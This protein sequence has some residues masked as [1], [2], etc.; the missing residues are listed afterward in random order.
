MPLDRTTPI[1]TPSGRHRSDSGARANHPNRNHSLKRLGSSLL[2]FVLTLLVSFVTSVSAQQSPSQVKEIEDR[3]VKLNLDATK[4]MLKGE[5]DTPLAMMNEALALSEKHFGNDDPFTSMCLVGLGKIYINNGQYEQAKVTLFRALKTLERSPF[6]TRTEVADAKQLL[7]F[8]YEYQSDYI[9]A[10]Q[11]YEQSLALYEAA[12]G[13][14][15]EQVAQ[16]LNNLANLYIQKAD[17]V[18]AAQMLER[19]LAIRQRVFGPTHPLIAIVLNNLA[20]VYEWQGNVARAEELFEQAI[21]IGEKSSS[22]GVGL[23]QLLTNLGALYR[24]NDP[25]KARILLERGLEMREKH[26]GPEAEEVGNSLNNLALLDWQEGK[27]KLSEQKLLR[28]LSILQKTLGP[29]HPDT[30][31]IVTNLA[32]LYSAVGERERALNLLMSGSDNSDRHLE[33][34]LTTGSEEQKRLYM[35]TLSDATSAFVSLHL[36]YNFSNPLAARLALTRILRRKGRILDMMSGQFAAVEKS[37]VAGQS[38]ITKLTNVRGQLSS[39]SIQGPLNSEVN[40]Y[41]SQLSRL[42]D[43]VQSLEKSITERVANVASKSSLLTI[44]DVQKTIPPGFALVEIIQY[45]PMVIGPKTLPRWEDPHYA[46]YVLTKTGQPS[47]IDLGIAAKIDQS[48]KGLRAAL[49]NPRRTDFPMLARDV[50]ERVM[51]PIR[52]LLGN[53]KQVLLAPDGML[54][55]APFAAFQNEHNHFLVEDYS[56]TYLTSGR[57]LLRMNNSLPNRQGPVIIA[58]PL[59]SS[60]SKPAVIERAGPIIGQRSADFTGKFEPLDGTASEA[61][62]LSSVLI[63]PKVFTGADATETALKDLKGPIILHI[64]THGFFLNRQASQNSSAPTQ[65][66]AGS[67]Y[68]AGSVLK[69]N[70]LLL[71][72]LALAGANQLSDGHG[73]DGILTALEASSLDLHGTKLVVL[74]ACETG[75]G[76]V[77]NGEGVYGLRRALVLAGAESALISLWK[78]DDEATRALMVDFYKGM[79]VG[80][81]RAD[82]IRDVQLNLMK[83]EGYQHP[84][85]W[86]AFI[87]SGDWRPIKFDK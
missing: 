84:F 33:V 49:R 81:S 79:E 40:L 76:E 25:K 12:T 29:A 41:Q 45:R 37:D 57:D 59:F 31:R 83:I 8:A 6:D 38:L 67:A 54:N 58:N 74:S 75:I 17:Y 69:E 70:P 52:F 55:L 1:I 53:I 51:R 24:K 50:D 43:Q 64:A 77:Q 46:A 16:V 5:L 82:A 48:V 68:E 27:P 44:E 78:V 71:S 36:N 34:M 35:A 9:R 62:Q 73:D 20:S 30:A 15:S 39:L 4:L 22:D 2:A 63:R 19:S 28:G 18:L 3:V 10:Q 60:G 86:A 21:A 65:T 85:F 72:G 23:A 66:T 56:I 87:L 32:L 80:K 26:L 42:Q 47:A 11:Y 7:A 14:Q 13:P 61:Q